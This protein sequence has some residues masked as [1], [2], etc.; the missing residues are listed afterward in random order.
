[1]AQTFQQNAHIEKCYWLKEELGGHREVLSKGTLCDEVMVQTTT[2]VHTSWNYCDKPVRHTGVGL[3]WLLDDGGQTVPGLWWRVRSLLLIMA[4]EV[5]HWYLPSHPTLKGCSP[6]PSQLLRAQQVAQI[7]R[8]SVLNGSVISYLNQLGSHNQLVQSL[9]HVQLFANPRTAAHQASLSI[10][11][12]RS[13]PKLMSIESVMP[14][15][16]L[17][18]CRP[19]SS[20]LQSF[21]TSGSFQMSQFFASGGQNTGSFSFNISPS[22]EHPGLISFRMDWLDLLAVQGT[23]KSLLQ[24]HSSKH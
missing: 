21:P 1:M 4:L 3:E 10:T 18:L 6:C 9:S 7:F 20:C 24:H 8:D 16:H 14:S 17:I 19:F 23:L 12:P 13:L 15:S 2:E 11:N 5:T 22:N